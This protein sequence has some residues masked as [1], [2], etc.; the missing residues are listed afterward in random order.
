MK[1]SI[2][3]LIPLLGLTT[4]IQPL[5]EV[6]INDKSFNIQ[7]VELTGVE[8]Q[9][10]NKGGEMSAQAYCP[11]PNYPKS[12]DRW[13]FCCPNRAVGCCRIQCCLPGTDFCGTDGRC[14]RY[15]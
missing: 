10:L 4:A 5:P 6:D 12:C 11:D 2:L 13:N 1:L 15:N 9:S 14:Y 8:S 3:A 7:S